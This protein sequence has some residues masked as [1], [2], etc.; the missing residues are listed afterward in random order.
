MIHLYTGDG[1]GKTTAAVGLT[2]RA[3]GRGMRICFA[4]FMK[5]GDSG[6][7]YVLRKLS[8][9]NILR[10]QKEFGFYNTLSEAEKHELTDIH[11]GILDSLLVLVEKGSCDMIVL[12]ELTYPIKWDLLDRGRLERLFN[13][14]QAGPAPGGAGD[15]ESVPELVITGRDP[16]DFLLKWADYITSM[17]CVRHPYDKGVQARIGIEY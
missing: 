2:I 5:G 12:D 10:S 17:E 7:L 13:F 15:T 8:Q 16:E 6:E 1:K 14:A 11:N 3:A 9:V 4:Q